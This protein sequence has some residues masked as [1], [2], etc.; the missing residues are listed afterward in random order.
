MSSP[1]AICLVCQGP[2]L[3][4]RGKLVCRRCGAILETCCEGG[5]M[6]TSG[7]QQPE[8]ENKGPNADPS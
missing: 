4:I 3:E 1:H 7:C 2:T 6:G 8:D 5:P